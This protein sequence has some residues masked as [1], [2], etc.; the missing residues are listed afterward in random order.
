MLNVST[1]NGVSVEYYFLLWIA[2]DNLALSAVEG[3]GIRL[4]L[5]KIAKSLPVP[6]RHVLTRRC[7]PAVYGAFKSHVES[8]IAKEVPF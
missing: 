2:L 3:R 6:S 7:L 4:F 1:Y 5:R 8:L